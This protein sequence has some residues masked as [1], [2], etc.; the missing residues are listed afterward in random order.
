MLE[1]A[2]VLLYK[3]RADWKKISPKSNETDRFSRNLGSMTNL[4]RNNGIQSIYMTAEEIQLIKKGETRTGANGNS[5]LLNPQS[6]HA[7]KMDLMA[8]ITFSV[9]YLVFNIIYF[10]CFF[11]EL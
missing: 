9:S 10:A 3:R 8:F 4:R 5:P 7:T 6:K 2:L 1:F 11:D